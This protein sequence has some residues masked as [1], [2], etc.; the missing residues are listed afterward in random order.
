MAA[1]LHSQHPDQM[2][3]LRGSSVELQETNV[4]VQ[5]FFSQNAELQR[6]DDELCRTAEALAEA[7]SRFHTILDNM[8]EGVALHELVLDDAGTPIDDIVT[9][10]NPRFAAVSGMQPEQV[11]FR[12]S[13]DA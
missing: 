7:D 4:L 9:A 5:K 6:A 13:C 11:L 1:V 12:S 3:P 2:A 8:A 10:T